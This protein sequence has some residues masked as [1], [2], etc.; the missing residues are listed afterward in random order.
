MSLKDDYP[1]TTICAVLKL[2]RSS[3]Y[4]QGID[5]DDAT[6][7]MAIQD[8]A[9]QYPTYGYRRITALLQRSGWTVNH[10]RIQRLMA[11]IGLQRAQQTVSTAL[12]AI[13]TWSKTLPQPIPNTCG[14]R[15][16]PMCGYIV[17]LC[18]WRLSWMCSRGQCVVGI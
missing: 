17:S 18:I 10:K 7:R 8:L 12:G 9:A 3:F 15:T 13:P 4:Y 14:W 5:M 6:L 2:P 1:V 16:S 11:E